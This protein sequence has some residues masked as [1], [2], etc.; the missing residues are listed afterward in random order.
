MH[1]FKEDAGLTEVS[2]GYI[3]AGDLAGSPKS[4]AYAV[5]KNGALE[6]KDV[7]KLQKCPQ[8]CPEGFRTLLIDRHRS[9][10]FAALYL[11]YLRTHI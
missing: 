10:N 7:K 11:M 6:E 2:V 8:A 3:V 5:L 4:A 1:K 9:C